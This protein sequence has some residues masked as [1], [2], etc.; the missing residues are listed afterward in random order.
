MW[1]RHGRPSTGGPGGGRDG[2]STMNRTLSRSAYPRVVQVAL[3][4]IGVLVMVALLAYC[5][6]R[7]H[8]SV[9][10]TQCK[11]HLRTLYVSLCNEKAQL[12][13]EAEIHDLARRRAGTPTELQLDCPGCNSQ[14]VYR[15]FDGPI[16]RSGRFR[17]II[18]WCPDLCHRRHRNVL[19]EDGAVIELEDKDSE[20][21]TEETPVIAK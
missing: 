7:Y 5:V 21:L 14:Y 19:L 1:M 10:D 3:I 6:V 11:R 2:G 12:R 4:S 20:L 17:R 18:A 15:P 8:Q 16:V 13:S 9:L